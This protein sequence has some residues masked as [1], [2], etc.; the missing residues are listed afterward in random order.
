MI[1][2]GRRR[3]LAAAHRDEIVLAD[4][5]WYLDGRSGRDAYDARAP[6]R[7]GVRRPRRVARRAGHAAR[8]AATRCPT[9][10][11]SRAAWPGSGSATATPSSPT[12][13]QGGVDGRAAR[14]DAA[15][16][17]PRRRAARRR[18]RRVGRA[19]RDR[20]GPPRPPATFT[21]ASRGR[22]TGSRRRRR[23]RPGQRRDRRPHR[24][25]ATSARGPGRPASRPHPRRA[26]PAVPREPRPATGACCPPTSCARAS[27]RPASTARTPVVSYC[28]SGVTACHNLLA[29]EHAGLGA[30]RL[31][32][33][34][35]SQWSADERRPVAT[36]RGL[37]PVRRRTVRAPA[38]RTMRR[39]G[40]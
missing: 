11:C 35:W 30:G 13:T 22:R 17:R 23:R 31:Y 9:R 10:R 20:A 18:H 34:S 33:G 28:G 3:R 7:R 6:A 8:A 14:V 40:R 5:R 4:V 32:P 15:R 36:G 16:D 12:T 39:R 2:P 1:A 24:A 21:R 25:S 26:Q 37:T 19:A 38:M 29:I 27:R